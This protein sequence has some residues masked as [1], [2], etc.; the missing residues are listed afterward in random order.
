M[1]CELLVTACVWDLVPRPGIEPRPPPALGA[2]SLT[3]WTTRE[4]PGFTLCT[5]HL[6]HF[7]E[8]M[9]TC[10]HHDSVIQ[11]S[12]T[13]LKFPCAPPIQPYPPSPIP[14]LPVNLS[15]LYRAQHW[16]VYPGGANHTHIGWLVATVNHG[17]SVCV[18]ISTHCCVHRHCFWDHSL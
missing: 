8:C 18:A 17:L 4:V 10:I 3:H 12:F 15:V 5:V 9:M 2:W 11:S 1:A 6:T 13:A 14:R 16:A 7:A